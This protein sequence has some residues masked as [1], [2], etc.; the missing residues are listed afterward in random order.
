MTPNSRDLIAGLGGGGSGKDKE[1][2]VGCI[3]NINRQRYDCCFFLSEG[4]GFQVVW[5]ARSEGMIM[6][7]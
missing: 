7:Y 2:R 6:V 5:V 1:R 4:V 3:L